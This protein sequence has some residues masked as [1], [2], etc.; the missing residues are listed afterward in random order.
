MRP[1][2]AVSHL[3]F[4]FQMGFSA[5]DAVTGL[6]L[7]EAGVPKEQ[8]ALLA[9]P[10]VPLQIL[11]PVVISKYTAGPRP[12]DVFYKA[13]PFRFFHTHTHTVLHRLTH[14]PSAQP[15]RRCCCC[16]AA[17]C[18]SGWATLCWCG[19]PPASNRTEAFLFTTTPSCC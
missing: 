6:K 13:F 5:A 18:S 15:S 7:V 10:M 8:M 4:L 19:G 3:C 16:V 11:L 14:T 9:V 2:L 17:G 12:L 1:T